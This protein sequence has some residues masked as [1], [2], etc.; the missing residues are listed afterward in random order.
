MLPVALTIAGSDCGGGAGIQADIRTFH[1]LGVYG[2][3]AI[4]L[5][6]VQNSRRFSR[7]QLLDPGLIREQIEAVLEDFAPGAVK[8]GALGTR[9]AVE[10]VAACDFSHPLV[11]DPV[12]I[13]KHGVALADQSVL[14]ALRKLLLPRA[15]LITPNLDE[16]AA[17]S[18]VPVGNV[19]QMR[20]AAERMAGWGAKAVLIKG[21]HLE[22]DAVDV[23]WADG[24]F[25]E[26]R[27]P[28]IA[29]KHTHGTGCTLSAAITA[30][31]ARGLPMQQAVAGGKDF[32]TEAIRTAPGLGG[33]SG[34]LNHWAVPPSPL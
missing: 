20:T 8:T 4:T 29:T 24:A 14:P 13:S 21:G 1:Q 3:C 15:A 25:R 12:L 2:T 18:G 27:A 16:A 34:P 33:G 10:A 9:A 23:L 6:T 5:V 31:L 22:G 11:I 28:R 17:L 19:D 32:V 30:L 26:F 7:V